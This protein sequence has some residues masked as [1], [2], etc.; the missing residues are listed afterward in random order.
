MAFPGAMPWRLLGAAAD[1]PGGRLQ[2]ER[3]RRA[4]HHG[5][6]ATAAP[7]PPPVERLPYVPLRAMARRLAGR[8]IPSLELT[9]RMLGRIARVDATLDSYATVMTDHALDAARRADRDI[10]AGLLSR[11]LAWH[12]GGREATVLLYEGRAHDGWPRR[13]AACSYLTRTPPSSR[14]C[15]RPVP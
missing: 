3:K 11:S 7:A 6:T 5:P 15:K 8:E 2:D 4:A 1:R 9:Q 13:C 12:A 10:A 14:V